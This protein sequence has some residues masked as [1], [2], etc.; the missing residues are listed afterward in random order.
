MLEIRW[1]NDLMMRHSW[2]V[3]YM[4]SCRWGGVNIIFGF[5]TKKIQLQSRISK[6]CYQRQDV[7]TLDTPKMF[8]TSYLTHQHRH[9]ERS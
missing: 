3:Q 5:L 8:R 2:K 7:L 1:E 6:E 9:L 4:K